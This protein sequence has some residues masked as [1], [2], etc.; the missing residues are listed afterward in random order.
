M[1]CPARAFCLRSK[2]LA[3]VSLFGGV[4]LIGMLALTGCDSSGSDDGTG[5][6]G[7]SGTGGSGASGA[8]GGTGGGGDCPEEG[9]GTIEIQVNGV[10]EGMSVNVH[11]D[12]P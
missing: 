12:G 8:T 2:S 6:T 1:S 11:V 3:S 7:A 10:P 4:A 5:A 9:S